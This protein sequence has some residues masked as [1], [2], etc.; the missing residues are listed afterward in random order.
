MKAY[1]DLSKKPATFN[2]LT[3]L[4]HAKTLGATEVVFDVSKGFQKKKFPE[5]I[6]K[7]MYENVLIPACEIWGMDWREGT[8][9][10]FSPSYFDEDLIRTYHKLGR[11]EKPVMMAGSHRYTVTIRESIRNKHRDSHRAAWER[12]ASEIGAYV[13][14]D[15]YKKP[16]SLKDRFALYASK[17]N[18]FCS[19]GPGALCFYSDAPYL[20]FSPPC[21]NAT[22]HEVGFQF[23][24]RNCNQRIVWAEDTLDNIREAFEE[25]SRRVATG[26]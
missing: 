23:P 16:L 25:H 15:A 18:F 5:Y 22:V 24:W 3:W 13:I 7:Q 1:Y 26:P 10:D 19:N 4:V 2:F 17:M 20:F 14:E 6:G 11:I 21:A 12:F 8:D 9:G